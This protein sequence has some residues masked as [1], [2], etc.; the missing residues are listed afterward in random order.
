MDTLI[1]GLNAVLPLILLIV[2]GYILRKSN[3]IN[4]NFMDIANKIVFRIALPALLFFNIYSVSGLEDI[5]WSVMIYA[6][7]GIMILLIIGI[8]SAKFFIKDPR[9]KGVIIQTTLRAN[10][11]IIGI[12]LA[13]SIGGPMA[14]ANVAIIALVGI[15]LMS[16][17]SVIVLSSFVKEEDLGN[18]FKNAFLKVVKNPLIIGVAIGL[19]ALWIRTLIPIDPN[20]QELVFSL[21]NNL[22]FLYTPIRWLGQI[23]SPVALIVLGA[24]F[25]FDH[26]N[27]LRKQIIIGTILRSLIAPFIV[28]GLAIILAENTVFF[29]FDKD[30]YPALISLF[31]SPTA[32]TNAVMVREMKSDEALSVQLVVFTTIASIFTIFIIVVV[33][34]NFGLL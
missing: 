15:P 16:G 7:I 1:F 27:G 26:I 31:G 10:F 11:A 3:F 2:L 32:I 13:E 18:P 19:L 5:N 20:T 33:F 14:V 29:K 25:K 24:T 8:I 22:K 12:P 28:L 6:V 21:K 30:V 23:T 4:D 34:R 9:Q 17:I